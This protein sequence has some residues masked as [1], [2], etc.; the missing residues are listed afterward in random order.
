MAANRCGAAAPLLQP[1]LLAQCEAKGT[2]ARL[3]NGPEAALN[4]TQRLIALICIAACHAAQA[5]RSRLTDDVDALERGD[6]ELETGFQRT[7]VRGTAPVRES[8]MQ[9]GCGIGWQSELAAAFVGRRSAGGHEQAV[10]LEVKTTLRER[11]VDQVG[12]MLVYGFGAERAGGGGPWRRTEQFI[13]V[14]ATL[15]PAKA[16][17]IEAKIAT[18]RDRIARRDG[19]LWALAVEN[20]ITEK[21]EARAELGG[22]DRSRPVM[23]VAL[24]YLIWPDHALVTLSYG[25]K[26]TP[27]PERRVGLGITFE[28]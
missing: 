4:A 18:A 14:E 1:A 13:A 5:D 16:W 25:V 15:Q 10:G 11:G 3:D 27:L 24:R 7:A 21:V 12:W 28:F 22:D 26:A 19:T 8:A 2:I 23:S 17:L 6:C 9:L 20:A